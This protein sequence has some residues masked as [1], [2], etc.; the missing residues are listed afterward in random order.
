[1]ESGDKLHAGLI[2][3]SVTYSSK[4]L[5]R[6]QSYTLYNVCGLGVV[7]ALTLADPKYFDLLERQRV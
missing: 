2:L 3:D 6:F 1:M 4:G 5:G 7:D